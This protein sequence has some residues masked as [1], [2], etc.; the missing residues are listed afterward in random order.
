MTANRSTS[1]NRTGDGS[2]AVVSVA[3]LAGVEAE[4]EVREVEGIGENAEGEGEEE[5]GRIHFGAD[6]AGG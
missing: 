3:G 4:V 6:K 5:E 2:G 1:V